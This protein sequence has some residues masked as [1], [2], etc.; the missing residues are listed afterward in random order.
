M[1][2]ARPIDPVGPARASKWVQP[3]VGSTPAERAV[4]VGCFVAKVAVGVECLG[5]LGNVECHLIGG[6]ELEL[7]QEVLRYQLDTVRLTYTD[8]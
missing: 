1:Q 5:G 6:K 7:V 3:T 4:A 8:S 2:V